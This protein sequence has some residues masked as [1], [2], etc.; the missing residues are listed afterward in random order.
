MATGSARLRGISGG[1]GKLAS[2]ITMGQQA[3]QQGYDQASATQSRMA[4]ALAA[5]ERDRAA[6][7]KDTLAADMLRD[8]G[9]V[10]DELMAVN[11]GVDI[12]TLRAFRQRLAGQPTSVP[13]GPPADDGSMGVGSA[14]FTP[15]QESKIAQAL[16]RF[17]P[18]R[19]NTGDF[20]MQQWAQGLGAF[21]ES[22]L[23]DAVL[24]GEVP[25][26]RVAAS[27]AAVAG[28]PMFSTDATGGV[29]DVFGGKL[30]TDN[31]MAGS[32]IK[33]RTDQAGQARAAAAENWA[34][35]ANA[36]NQGAADQ[37]PPPG[38]RWNA[39]RTAQE[40][41]P[42]GPAD[43]SVK[44]SNT[45]TGPMSATLQK[46]LIEAD[47]TVQAAGG[48]VRA[49]ESALK[50][51]DQAYSGY[52]AK[53][54]AVLASNIPGFPDEGADATIDIDNLMTGQ[55]LE[56]LKS[57]FGAAPT[58]G[59]RKILMDMQ[60]SV[61]KT[62]AQRKAIMERAIAA[63][64]RRA[65]FAGNK[66]KAIREGTYLSEGIEAPSAPADPAPAAASGG[67]RYIGKE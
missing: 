9:G 48:V 41:I 61:D 43:P 22:D 19:T 49:L 20:N 36:R 66:A 28:K 44:G 34:Q 8:R 33:L 12:P 3:E 14:Q 4:Q 32:T 24:R 37:K 39:D 13:M 30:D 46:E 6:A 40:F 35:A 38:Y 60:A 21:R 10:A 15:E 53:G 50:Q 18:V 27:Q 63:A 16:T 47:D 51:N 56:S 1:F 55:G 62:P 57:I 42:G 45:R 52:F 67:F 31:A 11:A 59:E 26:G 17:M 5:I 29:L 64:R 65:M 25:A 58:E 2:A 54:R 7:E 23:G